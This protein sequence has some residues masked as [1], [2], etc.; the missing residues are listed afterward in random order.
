MALV[1]KLTRNVVSLIPIECIEC[2]THVGNTYV[3]WPRVV[4]VIKRAP[5]IQQASE[6]LG[7]AAIMRGTGMRTVSGI[8]GI[9]H[10]S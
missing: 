10:S 8:R 4:T 9:K 6:N 5:Q 1:Q 3:D 2:T 7:D